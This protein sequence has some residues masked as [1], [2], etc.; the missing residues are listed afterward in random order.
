LS[1]VLNFVKGVEAQ[2]ND[3]LSTLSER[4]R[5]QARVVISSLLCYRCGRCILAK[6]SLNNQNNDL[7][8]VKA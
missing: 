7:F 8:A 4:E 2:K 5:T 6:V 3:L 1:K